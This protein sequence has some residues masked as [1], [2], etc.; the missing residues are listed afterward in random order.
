MIPFSFFR[1]FAFSTLAKIQKVYWSEG[2][3]RLQNIR[4]ELQTVKQKKVVANLVFKICFMTD[5]A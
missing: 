2:T 5:L 1:L 4:T 3:M